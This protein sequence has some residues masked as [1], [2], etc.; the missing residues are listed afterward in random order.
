MQ[1]EAFTLFSLYL[2]Q[3]TGKN[4]DGVAHLLFDSV[5]LEKFEDAAYFTSD[6]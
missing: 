4:G 2:L 3:W 5:F 1:G 6:L